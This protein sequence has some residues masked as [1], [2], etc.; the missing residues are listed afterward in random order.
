MGNCVAPKWVVLLMV[1]VWKDQNRITLNDQIHVTG[2]LCRAEDLVL[3]S[4]LGL[5]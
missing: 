4:F 2:Y 1:I 3:V 5:N